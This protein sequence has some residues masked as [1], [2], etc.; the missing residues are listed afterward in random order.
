MTV[1]RDSYTFENAERF[2]KFLKDNMKQRYDLDACYEDFIEQVN[3]NGSSSYELGSAETK[4][5]RPETIDC[6]RIDTE[7]EEDIWETTFEF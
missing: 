3:G 4:S 5:G 1:K 6:H 7:V 2:E